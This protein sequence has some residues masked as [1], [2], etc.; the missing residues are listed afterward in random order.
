MRGWESVR[1]RLLLLFFHA[2]SWRETSGPDPRVL[3]ITSAGC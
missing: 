3:A 2:D 1:E